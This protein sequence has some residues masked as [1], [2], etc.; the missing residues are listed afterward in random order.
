MRSLAVNDDNFENQR[1]TVMEERRERVDNS[2][3]GEAF[4]RIGELSHSCWAY[5][6]PV[7]GSWEDLENAKL[8]QVRD[9]HK[10]WYRPD[11]AVLAISGD[12]DP[13]EAMDTV[14]QFFGGIPAGGERPEPD[15]REALRTEPIHERITDPL[16]QLPA[17]LLNLPAPPY[18][19]PDFYTYEVIETLLFRGPSSRLY[20]RLVI[21]EATAVQVGGG[22]EAHRGPSLFSLLGVASAG[23]ELS[24]LVDGFFA[25]LQRLRDTPVTEAELSKVLN[26]L[27]TGRVFGRESVLNRALA[28]GRSVLYHG[29]PHWEDTYLTRVARVTAEDIV[30]IAERDFDPELRVVLEVEPA[31]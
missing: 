27:K 14:H 25:E 24:P 9:F 12:F 17:V 16:A 3:Y 20:R 21:D 4:V 8:E 13:D 5:S 10:R 26:Q 22:Y 15:L 23:C 1:Q 29:D 7:I 6:H 18:G 2:P 28:L 30:R 19:D 31:G 11:N